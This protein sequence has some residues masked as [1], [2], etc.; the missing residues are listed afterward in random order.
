MLYLKPAV[1]QDMD[2]L[3]RQ[4]C[5]FSIFCILLLVFISI[6]KNFSFSDFIFS[7]F[8]LIQFNS[9]FYLVIIC[10]GIFMHACTYVCMYC[11]YAS[12]ILFLFQFSFIYFQLEFF[13]AST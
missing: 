3:T 11:V 6:F 13:S 7:D 8:I 9:I 5:Y 10:I 1:S 12:N 4:Q 2:T